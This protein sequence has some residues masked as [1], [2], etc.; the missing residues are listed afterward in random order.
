MSYTTKHTATLILSFHFTVLISC[1]M[2]TDI[3]FAAARFIIIQIRFCITETM[4]KS[5]AMNLE[6]PII[7][8]LLS[9]LREPVV[10]II[11]SL[12]VRQILHLGITK[13]SF[14]RIKLQFFL[15]QK[16]YQEKEYR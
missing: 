4:K 15:R 11:R 7:V 10:A 9:L 8:R 1:I 16:Q 3:S 14:T 2:N 5:G 13:L 12:S 6:V